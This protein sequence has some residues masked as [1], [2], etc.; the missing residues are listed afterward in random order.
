MRRGGGGGRGGRTAAC[1]DED[2]DLHRDADDARP[3]R[4]RDVA[5]DPWLLAGAV[6]EADQDGDG[7]DGEGGL[8]EG[9]QRGRHRQVV[10]GDVRLEA[11]ELEAGHAGWPAARLPEW[12]AVQAVPLAAAARSRPNTASWPVPGL[13]PSCG[14]RIVRSA[15]AL[16]RCCQSAVHKGLT[17]AGDRL[18]VRA[19]RLNV[20]RAACTILH[21]GSGTPRISRAE[22]T[23]GVSSGLT[24]ANR[25]GFGGAPAHLP[26]WAWMHRVHHSLTGRRDAH[27]RPPVLV[28]ITCLAFVHVRP[29]VHCA[30]SSRCALHARTRSVSCPSV[31]P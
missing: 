15:R 27:T 1:V 20:H 9:A 10:R 14:R 26:P 24:S 23:K 3:Q 12:M 6:L 29:L 30:S 4:E 5:L 8:E 7:Q 22:A 31:V 28:S 17:D 16:T 13:Q 11:P 2:G 18:P 25:H 19:A 21:Q